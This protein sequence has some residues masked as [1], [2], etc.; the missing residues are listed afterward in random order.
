MTL[1]QMTP[2]KQSF[3]CLKLS[4]VPHMG[5]AATIPKVQALFWGFAAPP[6]LPA[7]RTKPCCCTPSREKK[8]QVK[9]CHA[10]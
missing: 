9:F 2:Q 3:S 8:A 6:A 10:A 5:N 1:I 4:E 7:A